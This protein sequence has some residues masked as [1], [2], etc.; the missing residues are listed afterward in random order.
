MGRHDMRALARI[1]AIGGACAAL[2]A[3]AADRADAE[4]GFSVKLGYDRSV[5]KYD[6][7]ADTVVSTSSVTATYDIGDYSFDVVLPY[8]QEKGPGRLIT[9]GGRRP[10]VVAGPDRKAS[11]RGDVTVGMTRFLLNEDQHAVDLDLGAIYKFGTASV[12]KGL[13]TGKDDVSIQAALGRSLGDFNATLSAG[14]VFV[15]KPADQSLRDAAYGSFDLSYRLNEAVSAGFT[16]SAGAAV[17]K[18]ISGGRDGTAYVNFKPTKNFRV[19]V[20]YLK[21]WGSQSP[22]RGGGLT[23]ACDI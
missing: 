15:G 22:D 4:P 10:I 16:Y 6:Q 9:V 20:Y 2:A 18:G 8:L 21:G 19:E 12:D 13:G 23:L 17:V 3:P 14:Y 7:P 11:G 5:G 1:A